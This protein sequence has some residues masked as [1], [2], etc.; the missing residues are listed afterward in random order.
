MRFQRL[1]LLCEGD[2]DERFLEAVCVPLLRQPYD[3]VTFYQH[4]QKAKKEVRNFLRSIRQMGADSLYFRDL[5]RGPAADQPFDE[6]PTLADRKDRI[7]E[8]YDEIERERIVLVVQMI[9]GWYAA[10]V[11]SEAAQALGV[12]EKASTD[13]LVKVQFEAWIPERF[14]G[15]RIDFMQE[16]LKHFDRNT[17]RAKNESFDYFCTTFLP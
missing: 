9:E 17:A 6:G 13:D 11:G 12:S 4:A 14:G 3:S 15:S 5:D 1:F 2:D 7:R 16:L 8:R 10:G